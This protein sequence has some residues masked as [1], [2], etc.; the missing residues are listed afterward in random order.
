LKGANGK[1]RTLNVAGTFRYAT[2]LKS[3]VG[4]YLQF[5]QA[6]SGSDIS[7]V[8]IQAEN[9]IVKAVGGKV[10][11]DGAIVAS[12]PAK[13]G[14][15]VLSLVDGSYVLTG[16]SS[17]RVAFIS[18]KDGSYTVDVGVRVGAGNEVSG[19]IY[20]LKA[21][22]KYQ[23]TEAQSKSLFESFIAF[24]NIVV[25]KKH[26]RKTALKCCASIKTLDAKR[27]EQCISDSIASGKCYNATYKSSSDDIKDALTKN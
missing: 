21:P 18:Q 15:G 12:F 22:I 6:G 9:S 2:D 13:V 5:R 24:K 14:K 11:I 4:V 26:S 17:E 3:K 7:A 23:I 19:L 1:W 10:F 25:S 16:F 27:Y 20:D 8:T